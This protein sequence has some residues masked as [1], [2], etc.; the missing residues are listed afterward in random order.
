M[1]ALKD[2]TDLCLN[3][4]PNSLDCIMKPSDMGARIDSTLE[5][6]SNQLLQIGSTLARTRNRLV[7]PLHKLPEEILSEILMNVTF[8]IGYSESSI[9][10]DLCLIYRRLYGLLSVC[11]TWRDIIVTRGAFWS[12]IPIVENPSMNKIG[13]FELSIHRARGS[14]RHLV[15]VA[16]SPET[17]RDLIQALTKYGPH[18][19]TI[20]LNIGD[21]RVIVEAIELLLHHDTAKPLAE[22]SVQSIYAN[23][24]PDWLP[25]YDD[26]VIPLD[27]AH[28]SSF[29][30]LL[31]TL[32]VFRI[33]GAHFHWETMAFS[34][35]LVELEIENITLGYDHEIE[36]FLQALCSASELRD[37]RITTMD[38]FFIP[39]LMD[40]IELS[41]PV[42]FPRLQSLHV[43]DVFFN[44]LRLLLAMIAPG[45]HCLSLFLGPPSLLNNLKELDFFMEP[46]PEHEFRSVDIGNLCKI[47]KQVSVHTLMLSGAGGKWLTGDM[48]R[49]LME[50]V[51]TLKILKIHNWDFNR[52]VWTSLKRPMIDEGNPQ[53]RSFPALETIQLSKATILVKKGFQ[54]MVASHPLRRIA[55]GG[56]S[57]VASS[58]EIKQGPLEKRSSMVRWLRYNV[59]E[60]CLFDS[61][62]HP[63]EFQPGR[64][65]L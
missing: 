35:R 8:D 11:S 51:P 3:L 10:Q 5:V 1:A 17:F 18:I 6:I 24:A 22:L 7:T 30:S 45:S 48:L 26:Y 44:T 60:F 15:A 14:K 65:P 42:V 56:T 54:D 58:D 2:Y 29:V 20:N 38:T 27:Y 64:W 40:D 46:H 50:A 47:L 39:D 34:T 33:S 16:E 55:L 41:S 12:V 61:R 9:K 25:S 13:S 21:H 62:Y 57:R 63:P 4:S 43:Q 49:Q 23:N 19:D 32:T 52:T 59:P 28:Q 31:G 36:P 37:L 53:E